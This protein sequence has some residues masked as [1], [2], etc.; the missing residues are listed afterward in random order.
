MWGRLPP[1]IANLKLYKRVGYKVDRQETSPQFG[2][3]VYMSKC[4]L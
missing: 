2:V 1:R 4:L 3:A